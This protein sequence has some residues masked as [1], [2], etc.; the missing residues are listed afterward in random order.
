MRPLF[1]KKRESVGH[2]RGRTSSVAEQVVEKAG[3][4]RGA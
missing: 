1:R 3:R 4:R 2:P